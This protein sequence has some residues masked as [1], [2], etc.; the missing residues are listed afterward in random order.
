VKRKD[1]AGP[2]PAWNRERVER[3]FRLFGTVLQ[4]QSECERFRR[5]SYFYKREAISWAREAL[6]G[7]RG[8]WPLLP[9]EKSLRLAKSYLAHYRAAKAVGS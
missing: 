8:A 9:Y 4:A 3:D 1:E 7:L 2:S 6:R 5:S